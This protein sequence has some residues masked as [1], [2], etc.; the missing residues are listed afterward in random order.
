MNANATVITSN[1]KDF[2]AAK[3]ALGLR[4]MTPV[5]LVTQLCNEPLNF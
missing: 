3:N 5:E 4:V 1:V 2:K